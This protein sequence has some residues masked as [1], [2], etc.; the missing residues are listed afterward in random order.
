MSSSVSI[1]TAILERI[2]PSST[3]DL[4]K[5]RQQEPGESLDRFVTAL[6]QISD[7]CAFDA[8]TLDDLLRNRIIFGIA[9]H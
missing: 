2:F 8:I 1:T 4:F 9:D 7:K 5:S 3:N 6:R